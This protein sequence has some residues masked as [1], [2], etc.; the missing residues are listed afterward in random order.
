MQEMQNSYGTV[1]SPF[2][3]TDVYIVGGG[4]S[5]LKLDLSFLRG[6][7]VLAIN[8]SAQRVLALPVAADLAVVSLDNNWVRRN[9]EF[10]NTFQGEKFVALPLETWPDCKGIPGVTYLKWG[11]EE[12]LSAVPSILNTGGN[13]GYGAINLA[14]LK[15]ARRILLLGFDMNPVENVL[16]PQWIEQFRSAVPN[17]QRT[18]T[19]VLNLNVDSSIDAFQ[20]VDIEL[21]KLSLAPKR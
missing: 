19:E 4:P 20:K 7:K 6:K 11:Y 1:S 16:Y 15:R 12:G 17:L 2:W 13:S 18:R 21:F 14:Y 8:D 3:E 10:L 5:A 9:R